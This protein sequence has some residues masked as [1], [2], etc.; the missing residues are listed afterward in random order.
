M[1]T[2]HKIIVRPTE[3]DVNGH[4]NNTMYV[5]YGVGREE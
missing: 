5:E 1:E 3:F 4:V 2:A